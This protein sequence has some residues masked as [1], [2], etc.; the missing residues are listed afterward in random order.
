MREM[1]KVDVFNYEKPVPVI[2]GCYVNG[3]GL[4]RSFGE[5]GIPTIGLDIIRDI[6]TYSKYTKGYICPN[7]SKKEFTEYLKDLGKKLKNKGVLFA[8]Y[9]HWLIPI[10]KYQKDLSKYFIFPMSGWEVIKKSANKA[11]LY[12]IAEKND[13]PIPKTIF[14]KSISEIGLVKNE[15]AFPYVIKPFNPTC[16]MRTKIGKKVLFIQDKSDLEIWIKKI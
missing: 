9:D 11:L 4:I 3:L 6:G 14:L 5:L 12:K 7:P 16:F 13:I 10:S 8:T 15:I 1:Q 2:L